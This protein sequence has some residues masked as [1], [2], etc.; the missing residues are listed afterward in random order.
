MEVYLDNSATTKPHPLVIKQ[1]VTS[2]NKCYGNPSSLHTL[3]VEAERLIKKAK[4]QIA[5]AIKC[6]TEELFFTSGGTECNNLAIQ[7]IPRANYGKEILSSAIEHPA[8]ISAL[9]FME[10]QGYTIDVVGV[11]SK[12][13][14]NLKELEE[15]VTEKTVLVSLMHVNNEIGTI[16]PIK[17]ASQI[18]KS[19][20][21]KTIFHVDASQSFCKFPFSVSDLECD[22]LTLSS[23]KIHGPKGVGCLYIKRGTRISPIFFG[24]GQQRDLRP[25]TEDTIGISG[26]GL[27]VEICSKDL[28]K[29]ERKMKSTT[30]KLKDLIIKNID[31]VVI[32]T[33]EEN[34]APHILNVSFKGVKSQVLLA[35]L[36]KEGIYVSS[37]SA[38]SS[39]KDKP[40]YVLA[41]IGLSPQ[42]I[43][44]SIRFSIS[45]L[46]TIN[47]IRHT[48]LILSKLVTQLR[49]IN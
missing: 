26:F 3:G 23:H 21:L 39:Q 9:K 31:D 41:A 42:L 32:N 4:K 49:N 19:K 37:G 22:L 14:I 35:H 44:S 34:C 33:P 20:N 17:E 11:D 1:M 2:M 10:T 38:C 40:S 28:K 47:E 48:V 36:D 6:G 46:T 5:A 16:E 7:G 27:A 43:G 45:S 30:R 13:F 12:G 8:T 24:G 18:I 15:K 25:G 29:C